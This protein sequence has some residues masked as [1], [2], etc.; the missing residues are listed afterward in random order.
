ME[1]MAWSPTRF[2]GGAW[3]RRKRK[4]RGRRRRTMTWTSV[5]GKTWW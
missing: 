2:L 3:R 4:R 5:G 1:G